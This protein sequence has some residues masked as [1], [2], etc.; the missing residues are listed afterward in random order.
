MFEHHSVTDWRRRSNQKFNKYFLD[1]TELY[2]QKPHTDEA[3]NGAKNKVENSG[4]GGLQ[5]VSGCLV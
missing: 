2:A 3:N 4:G 1:M 5:P